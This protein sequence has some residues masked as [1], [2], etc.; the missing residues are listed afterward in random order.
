MNNFNSIY[1]VN[2]NPFN[3]FAIRIYEEILND[4]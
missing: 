4:E 3:Y 1:L 2:R